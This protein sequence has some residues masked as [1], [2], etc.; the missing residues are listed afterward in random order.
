[1]N[2]LKL[3]H[4]ELM[5]V[6]AIIRNQIILTRQTF[7]FMDYNEKIQANSVLE[8]MIDVGKKLL[9]TNGAGVIYSR[10]ETN[11]IIEMLEG[12]QMKLTTCKIY[13]AIHDTLF[14][15]D[16]KRIVSI[17]NQEIGAMLNLF[18]QFGQD[19]MITIKRKS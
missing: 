10:N 3:N 14:T 7:E 11:F 15:E 1:M 13:F 16:A 17:R 4:D 19:S 5:R 18:A 6:S 9:M 2:I 8:C 12:E